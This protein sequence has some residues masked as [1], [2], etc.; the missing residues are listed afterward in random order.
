MAIVKIPGNVDEFVSQNLVVKE[1]AISANQYFCKI[2]NKW[3]IDA[4]EVTWNDKLYKR[5]H[6]SLDAGSVFVEA[7]SLSGFSIRRKVR[8][9]INGR[10]VYRNNFV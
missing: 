9:I 1:G 5:F 8:R 3:V 2:P 4:V 7:G 10:V 6:N